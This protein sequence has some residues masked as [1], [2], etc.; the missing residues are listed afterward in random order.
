[1]SSVSLPTSSRSSS[2]GTHT[3]RL[4]W[5]AHRFVPSPG[6]G[7]VCSVLSS[8]ARTR[9]RNHHASRVPLPDVGVTFIREPC[10]PTLPRTLLPVHRSYGLIRQSSVALADF[11]IAPRSRSLCRLLPAPAATW[12]FLTLFCESFLRCLSP[13]PGG[14]LS[15]LAWFFLNLHRPSPS[16]DWVD[17]PAAFRE[18]DFPR[19]GLRGC[20]YFVMFTPPSLLASQIVPTAASFLAGQPRLLSPSRT[21][22]VTFARIG[23]AI[24]LTTGNCRSEDFHLARFA[25]LSAAHE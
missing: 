18:H 14:R 23:H 6:Y 16:F 2:A 22:V 5:F 25:A 9:R 8:R 11:G 4:D 19:V 3:P 15:A 7:L 10:P 17:I 13:Y 20:S 21:C 24:R 1:M 12:I